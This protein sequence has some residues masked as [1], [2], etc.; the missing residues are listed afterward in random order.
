MPLSLPHAGWRANA[1]ASAPHSQ[2]MVQEA[3]ATTIGESGRLRWRA[4]WGPSSARLRCV[5]VSFRVAESG[6]SY[7][8]ADAPSILTSEE[9]LRAHRSSVLVSRSGIALMRQQFINHRQIPVCPLCA[10]VGK[11]PPS[12]LAGHDSRGK[13][14]SAQFTNHI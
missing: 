3:D 5:L 10:G 2:R 7:G 13:D 4:Y 14:G 12:A 9:G 6:F 8:C 1:C 11:R